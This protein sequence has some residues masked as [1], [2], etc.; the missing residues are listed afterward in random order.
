M[1]FSESH[2]EHLSALNLSFKLWVVVGL[3]CVIVVVIVVVDA[4][5]RAIAV[6]K[7]RTPDKP[8]LLVQLKRLKLV[9]AEAK[10]GL[11]KFVTAAPASA[12]LRVRNS[13]LSQLEQILFGHVAMRLEVIESDCTKGLTEMAAAEQSVA[14]TYGPVTK[15]NA[16]AKTTKGQDVE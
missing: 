1:F 10:N 6:L 4:L 11:L 8:S 3:K 5:E 13:V 16:N 2:V 7:M 9:P 15:E 12:A 14:A